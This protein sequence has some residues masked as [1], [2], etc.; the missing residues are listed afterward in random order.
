MEVRQLFKR[1]DAWI[2]AIKERNKFASGQTQRVLERLSGQGT[3]KEAK[4]IMTLVVKKAVAGMTKTEFTS[5]MEFAK[6][7]GG[8]SHKFENIQ[9]EKKEG[10]SPFFLSQLSIFRDGGDDV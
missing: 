5:M 1:N 3:L 4:E 8:F 7:Y 10:K 9:A 2:K 6:K